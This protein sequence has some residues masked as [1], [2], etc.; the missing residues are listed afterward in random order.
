MNIDPFSPD[1]GRSARYL[2]Q[3]FNRPWLVALMVGSAIHGLVTLDLWWFGS[4]DYLRIHWQLLLANPTCAIIQLL[5][6]YF[7]PWIIT[8]MANRLNGKSRDDLLAAFPD[9]NPDLVIKLDAHGVPQYINR[10]VLQ[11]LCEAGLPLEHPEMILPRNYRQQLFGGQ[12]TT[13]RLWHEIQGRQ[14]EYLARRD[15]NTGGVFISGRVQVD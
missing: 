2:R 15:V 7:V 6:P 12:E 5:I 14:I 3:L 13:L 10:A 8:S 1:Q 4:V 11:R 9:T